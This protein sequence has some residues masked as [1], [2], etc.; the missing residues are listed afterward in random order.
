MSVDCA[1]RGLSTSRMKTEVGLQIGTARKLEWSWPPRRTTIESDRAAGDRQGSSKTCV[2][3]P[4]RTH[5]LRMDAQN[6]ERPQTSAMR[7]LAPNQA[8]F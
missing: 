3:R 8:P 2:H 4:A 7:R 5:R 6:R 1:H